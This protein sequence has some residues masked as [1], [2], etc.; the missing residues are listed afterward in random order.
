MLTSSNGIGK[1]LTAAGHTD[2]VNRPLPI[3]LIL[4][5]ICERIAIFF[6]VSQKPSGPV[7]YMV[8]EYQGHTVWKK[9]RGEAGLVTENRVVSGQSFLYVA[10]G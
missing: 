10:R 9:M 8:Q 2:S 3:D 4:Y 7:L 5:F 6:S 1:R